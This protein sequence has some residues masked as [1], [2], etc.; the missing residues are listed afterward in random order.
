MTEMHC[1]SSL[2]LAKPGELG[3]QSCFNT[4]KKLMRLDTALLDALAIPACDCRA[5]NEESF[6]PGRG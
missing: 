6:P 3:T 1:W 2:R 4:I 5:T